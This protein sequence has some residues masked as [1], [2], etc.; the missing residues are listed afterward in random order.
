MGKRPKYKHQPFESGTEQGKF[1][2]VCDDMMDSPAWAA[3]SLR[4]QGLYL[5]LKRKYTQKVSGGILI[6]DNADNISL[7]KSEALTMYG[8]LRSFRVDI[9]KLIA[10]GFIR[11]IQSGFNTRTVN[12]Y[13]FS[14]RWKRYGQTDF[15]VPAYEQRR[16]TR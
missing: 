10:C 14:D 11:L 1:T 16:A 6:S 9:D 2:K 3:L 7:P 4:Q 8:T 13:G 5:A 15:E 12:I